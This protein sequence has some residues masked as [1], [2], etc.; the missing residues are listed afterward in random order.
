MRKRHF[1][2]RDFVGVVFALLQGNEFP[3]CS[4]MSFL[5]GKRARYAK[6]YEVTIE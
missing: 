3:A 4:M 6:V 5:R 1:Q 2:H